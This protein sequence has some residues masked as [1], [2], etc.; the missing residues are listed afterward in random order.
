MKNRYFA[1][2]LLSSLLT[3][4]ITLMPAFA[5][6]KK[7]AVA[8][9][10]VQATENARLND[11]ASEIDS[12]PALARIS[13]DETVL[14]SD[15]GC[16]IAGFVLPYG[17]FVKVLNV[18]ETSVSV[19]YMDGYSSLPAR[20]GYI[21][22]KHYYAFYDVAPEQLYPECK[23]T[24]SADEVL[25]SDSKAATPKTVLPVSG[26]CYFYGYTYVDG[27]QYYCVYSGG[28]IGYVKAAAFTDRTIPAHPLPFAQTTAE[29]SEPDANQNSTKQTTPYSTD[30][31]SVIK[32][33]IVLA[34]SVVAL[35]VV[36]LLFKPDRKH[37][38]AFTD[39]DSDDLM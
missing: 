12:Y 4:L 29:I 28:Y 8:Y 33:V 39:K 22:T 16:T 6:N 32:T 37:R 24:L 27:E 31:D 25:F 13:D 14:Y 2:K 19:R 21:L 1:K 36:Y 34:V 9:Y 20:D 26:K 30:R 18:N 7:S 15:P 17:Y 35:S 5:W 10:N 11:S 38:F 3:I 23:L